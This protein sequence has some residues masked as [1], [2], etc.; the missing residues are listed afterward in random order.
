MKDT[1]NHI[2]VVLFKTRT[3]SF[4]CIPAVLRQ[5]SFE[6]V[7]NFIFNLNLTNPMYIGIGI[8]LTLGVKGT[9]A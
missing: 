5:T 8:I 3:R 7:S 6:T 1:I 2:S 4:V 9:I